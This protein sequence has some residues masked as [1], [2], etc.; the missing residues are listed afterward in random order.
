MLHRLFT[1]SGSFSTSDV[2]Y[3]DDANEEENYSDIA[4]NKDTNLTPLPETSTA[5][6]FSRSFSIG[7]Y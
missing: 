1:G 7:R 4:N 5:I 2:D 6:T 3:F